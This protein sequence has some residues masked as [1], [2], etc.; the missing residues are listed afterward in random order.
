MRLSLRN[1]PSSSRSRSA[2]ATLTASAALGSSGYTNATVDVGV[3]P[4]AVVVALRLRSFVFPRD[5][6]ST[7]TT[8][9]SSSSSVKSTVLAVVAGSVSRFVALGCRRGCCGSF[10]SSKGRGL[11]L[12]GWSRL[13]YLRLMSTI[14]SASPRPSTVVVVVD[15]LPLW[16]SSRPRCCCCCCRARARSS[17]CRT[18]TKKALLRR[19]VRSAV[20]V[21]TAPSGARPARGRSGSTK[22]SRTRRWN[23][24][25]SSIATTMKARASVKS[26]DGE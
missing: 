20:A 1:S 21:H 12:S 14:S 25:S 15:R 9:S 17:A 4:F 3:A 23:T 11:L 16:S 8:S 13:L 6:A 10:S 18:P 24:A 7:T 5:A 19:S 26:H 22:T 2:T